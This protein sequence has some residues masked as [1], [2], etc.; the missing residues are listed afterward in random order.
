MI[1]L[2]HLRKKI[3]KNHQNMAQNHQF[4][5]FFISFD[6]SR[7]S[8]KKYRIHRKQVPWKAQ[9]NRLLPVIEE[10]CVSIFAMLV[11]QNRQ[12]AAERRKK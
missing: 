10:F 5:P 3:E 9:N 12:I 8:T 4:S 2:Y 1:L 11:S 6:K 7:L